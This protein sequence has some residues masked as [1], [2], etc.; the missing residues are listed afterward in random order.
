M[1]VIGL[2]DGSFDEKDVALVANIWKS[3]IDGAVMK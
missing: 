1:D 2:Q 3:T